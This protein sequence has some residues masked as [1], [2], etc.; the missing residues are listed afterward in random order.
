MEK[1]KQFG[2]HDNLHVLIIWQ[3]P[4]SAFIY[5]EFEWFYSSD[6]DEGALSD[7]FWTSQN[8]SGYFDTEQN[9]FSAAKQ[10]LSWVKQ[11]Y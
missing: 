10:E 7:G 5:E 2:S 9:C 1:I 11:S 8:R 6:E 4:Y 3:T